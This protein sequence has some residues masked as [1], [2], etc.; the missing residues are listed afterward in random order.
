MRVLRRSAV[1]RHGVADVWTA[2]TDPQALAEWLMPTTFLMAEVGHR[3]RFQFDPEPLCPTGVVECEVTECDPPRRMV[4]SW[5]HRPVAG[6]APPPT[7]RVEWLLTPVEGG[8]RLELVQTGLEGQ[9]WLIPLVMGF[10]WRIYLRRYLPRALAAISDGGYR[11]GAIP[12]A[13]RA[14]KAT[15]LPPEV[16]V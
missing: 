4:W 6:K 2:L 16:T 1:Y 7:M 10:G 12:L 13:K 15:S 14:Y 5:A 9:P 11:K 8:T 3:F